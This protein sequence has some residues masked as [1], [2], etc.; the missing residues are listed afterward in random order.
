[1]IYG[2]RAV[3]EAILSGSVIDKVMMLQGTGSELMKELKSLCSQNQV[4]VKVVQKEQFNIYKNKNHQGVVAFMSLVEYQDLENIVHQCFSSGKD[5]LIL[6]L[7]HITDV[8]NFGAI[9]RTAEV[10]GVDAIVVPESGSAQI[11]DDAI[12]TSAGAISHLNICRSKNLSQT[13]SILKNSGLK[14]VACTEKTKDNIYKSTLSGPIA[15]IM[16]NEEYGIDASLLKS[17]DQWVSIPQLGK[18]ESLN[19][20]V[21][22]GVALFEII[23]QRSI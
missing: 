21:A 8:R 3:I 16:G 12:K 14:V 5:P 23:R 7:D 17:T 22:T 15:L 19:V 13:V 2:S 11:N 9:C 18:I 6:I 10:A 4:P 1:M 20:S